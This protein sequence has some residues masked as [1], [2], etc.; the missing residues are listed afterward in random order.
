MDGRSSVEDMVP[1]RELDV[2]DRYW[3]AR[4]QKLPVNMALEGVDGTVA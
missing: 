1:V 2:E 3:S 4:S